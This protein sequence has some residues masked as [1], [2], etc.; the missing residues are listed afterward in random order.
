MVF[1][2]D[3]TPDKGALRALLTIV[4]SQD[5][6]GD[7]GA[8][9]GHY[10]KWYIINILIRPNT[11]YVSVSIINITWSFRADNVFGH[12]SNRLNETGI[13][14]AYAFDGAENVDE[15]TGGQVSYLDLTKEN[16]LWKRF[17]WVLSYT[18]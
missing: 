5:E 18:F 14:T 3:N 2:E 12:F 8:L 15:I 1:N 7:F 13:V 16:M 9:H 4:Q 6:I 10:S 11:V 17:D